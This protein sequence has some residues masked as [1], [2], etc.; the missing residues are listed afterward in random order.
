MVAAIV[1]IPWTPA[2]AQTASDGWE[3]VVEPY[4]MA[5]A[6]NGEPATVVTKAWEQV[7]A[8]GHRAFWEPRSVLVT[9]AGQSGQ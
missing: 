5:V 2:A 7:A 3:V 6:M 8:V 9:G 1:A 4:L